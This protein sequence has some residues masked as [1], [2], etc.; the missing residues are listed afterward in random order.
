MIFALMIA[1]GTTAV[2]QPKHR[3]HA[4]ADTAAVVNN[5]AAT[6]ADKANA[7]EAIEAF[8][9]TTS[10]A[11]GNSTVPRVYVDDDFDFVSDD[12][13]DMP[14]WLVNFLG[15][16]VDVVGG[17][18]IIL[19]LVFAVL[20][21][22]APFIVIVLIIVL[23]MRYLIRRH[24]DRVALASK[25]METGQ[26]IP[27]ELMPVDKQSD[28]YLRRRGIRNIWIG[29]GMMVMFGIWDAD[30]LMGIGALVLC[31]G[32][33]Q[34]FIARSSQKKKENNENINP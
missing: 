14:D 3:H 5:D 7:D 29:I 17:I 9:D 6:A 28:D 33:G 31:Y 21:A 13:D 20:L 32:I 15:G 19:M 25:A 10:V 30:M 26:P 34:I 1:L 4:V 16:S 11:V 8:S 18:F 2:A 23:I 22:L 12:F 27:E 24:N